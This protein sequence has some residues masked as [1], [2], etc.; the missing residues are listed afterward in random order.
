M[1]MFRVYFIFFRKNCGCDCC[2]FRC[3]PPIPQYIEAMKYKAL[4]EEIH[5]GGDSDNYFG[6]SDNCGGDSDNFGG[7]SDNDGGDSDKYGDDVESGGDRLPP[8]VS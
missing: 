8:G 5:C 6:D 4:E 2:S 3:T 7:D 1:G